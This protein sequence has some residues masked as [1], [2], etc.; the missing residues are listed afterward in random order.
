MLKNTDSE[1]VHRFWNCE[2][3]NQTEKRRKVIYRVHGI[4]IQTN[5][6]IPA[7]GSFVPYESRNLVIDCRFEFADYCPE[8]VQESYKDG[9]EVLIGDDGEG[10]RIAIWDDEYIRMRCLDQRIGAYGFELKED[11][12]HVICYHDDSAEIDNI[13][14]WINGL[15]CSAILEL[16]GKTALHCSAV[17]IS[18]GTV[19]FLGKSGVGKSTMA[20]YFGL[21]GHPILG[22]D[23]LATQR[24]GNTL[25][26]VGAFP[27]MNLCPSSL[28]ITD[29]HLFHQTAYDLGD[30]KKLFSFESLG[31]KFHAEANAFAGICF[32]HPSDANRLNVTEEKP[33]SA[34][35]DL[36]SNLGCKSVL[37]RKHVINKVLADL[38]ILAQS[39]PIFHFH[40]PR[41]DTMPD[42]IY[43]E[44]I[45]RFSS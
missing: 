22:D 24:Q 5:K 43:S 30:D 3:S 19:I 21:R 26:A 12:S 45:T 44:I 9:N 41:G 8:W 36:I 35:K 11:G 34:L 20:L 23:I 38:S 31:I 32:L 1:F 37:Y 7:W 40:V 14:A 6:I 4:F 27:T 16:S 13:D 2:I 33:A 18:S 15:I 10:R 28:K 29:S 42:D 17:K 39:V 25:K